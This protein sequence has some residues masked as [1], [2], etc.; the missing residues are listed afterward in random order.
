MRAWRFQIFCAETGHG[1]L[2]AVI[3]GN[4]SAGREKNNMHRKSKQSGFSMLELIIVMAVIAIMAAIATP[5]FLSWR[6]DFWL[7]G[8]AR[9][10]L[11]NMQK[12]KLTSIKRRTNVTMEFDT[13][14]YSYLAYIDGDGTTGYDPTATDDELILSETWN[15]DVYFDTDQSTDGISFNG[16]KTNF[17]PSG[18]PTLSGAIYIKNDNGKKLS[19]A[20]SAAGNIHIAEY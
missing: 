14:G 11:G 10:L 3:V 7:K 1:T 5:S 17:Q 9:D 15:D 12:A 16:N 6:K 2:I 8:A 19:I 4:F 13:G 18:I 20:L